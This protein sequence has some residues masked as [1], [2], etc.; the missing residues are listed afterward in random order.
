MYHEIFAVQPHAHLCQKVQRS[1]LVSKDVFF[2]QMAYLADQGY[3]SLSLNNLI[4]TLLGKRQIQ[5]KSI[6]ITFD[7]GFQGNYYHAFPILKEFN[8]K[9]TF[10][11][12]AGLVGTT[13]MLKWGQVR[14]MMQEGMSIGSHTFSH[15]LLS[16]LT[17]RDAV[18]EITAS[19]DIIERRVKGSVKYFS[20]PNGDYNRRLINTV[21][22]SAYLAACSSDFGIKHSI[23]RRFCLKRVKVSSSYSLLQYVDLV[24]CR[25]QFYGPL[26]SK[27]FFLTL[28]KK[29]I[30]MDNYEK[31][32]ARIF[33]L[34][35]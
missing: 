9:A 30:G 20:F 28:I 24:S 32:Y 2:R 21:E 5:Q 29:T 22:H 33:N 13:A 7:D 17:E 1:Y 8:L 25:K 4:E 16:T 14:E 23:D 34:E 11:I 19:K 3:T 18:F 31:L 35:T 12:T 15:P 6:L 10:F 27:F 26:Y